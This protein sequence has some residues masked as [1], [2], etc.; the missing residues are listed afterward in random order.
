M[1][2]MAQDMAAMF[3]TPR[4]YFRRQGSQPRKRFG[5]HF[6]QQMATAQRIVHSANLTASDVVVEVGPGLGA[7]TQFILGEVEE[8]HLVE[9]DRDLA[10]Y[11]G[12]CLESASDTVHIHRQD[13]LTFDFLALSRLLGKRLVIL[14]N[15]P[16]NISSPLLFCLVKAAPCLKHAVFMVQKEVGERLLANPG[17]K[18]YGVLSVLL[19][20]CARVSRLFEVGAAQFYPPPRVDSLVIRIDFTEVPVFS[21]EFLAFF[22]RVVNCAFQQRRKILQNSLRSVLVGTPTQIAEAC[23]RAGIDPGRRPETLSVS[24]FIG[25]SEVLMSGLEPQ[26]IGES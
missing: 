7:L 8:L 11:L 13:V 18:S 6:L 21:E 19:G 1:A 12:G 23:L 26:R 22:R 16:Y 5:Q 20:T 24:E 15:L 10:E 14:G 25:L 17:T 3:L 2:L 4:Q 9:L